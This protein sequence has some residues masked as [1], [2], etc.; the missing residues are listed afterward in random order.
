MSFVPVL[1]NEPKKSWSVNGPI[2]LS[3][4]STVNKIIM[5]VNCNNTHWVKL[6]WLNSYPQ[7]EEKRSSSGKLQ[8]LNHLEIVTIVGA[9]LI[10]HHKLPVNTSRKTWTA[11]KMGGWGGGGGGGWG[12]KNEMIEWK[13]NTGHQSQTPARAPTWLCERS[14]KEA[15][16]G[17]SAPFHTLITSQSNLNTK[18]KLN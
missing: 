11:E 10:F 13:R 16:W 12:E 9:A 18:R 4:Y 14:S 1:V 6:L 17:S 5:E 2:T 3:L 8:F 15:D 7:K